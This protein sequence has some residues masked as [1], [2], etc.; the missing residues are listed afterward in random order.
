MSLFEGQIQEIPDYQSTKL[1]EFGKTLT[2]M[3]TMDASLFRDLL[4]P[5]GRSV[6]TI[7]SVSGEAELSALP[8][9]SG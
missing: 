7:S 1:Q 8:Y 5:Y 3:H 4:I 9:F 6:R 2:P